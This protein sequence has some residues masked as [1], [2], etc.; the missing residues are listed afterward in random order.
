MA[1]RTIAPLLDRYLGRTGYEAQ[2]TTTDPLPEIGVNLYEP[3]PGDHRA[4][5]DFDARAKSRSL[6]VWADLHKGA[7]VGV[8]ALVGAVGLASARSNGAGRR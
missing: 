3:V 7:L 6:Q 1:N 2:Q 8:G 5:R 4:H